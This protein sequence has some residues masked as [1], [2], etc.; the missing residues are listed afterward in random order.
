MSNIRK[1]KARGNR[2]DTWHLGGSRW[3]SVYRGIV[4]RV[5]RVKSSGKNHYTTVV[6]SRQFEVSAFQT[7]KKKMWFSRDLSWKNSVFLQFFFSSMQVL[8]LHRHYVERNTRS[9]TKERITEIWR[10]NK[11]IVD[12]TEKSVTIDKTVSLS[13]SLFFFSLSYFFPCN[14]A[15]SSKI[16]IYCRMFVRRPTQIERFFICTRR[17]KHERSCE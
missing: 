12:S 14:S 7:K 2:S 5:K 13:L 11:L 17:N 1:Q 15:S 6:T 16:S 4:K 9:C 10:D 3:R 8:T